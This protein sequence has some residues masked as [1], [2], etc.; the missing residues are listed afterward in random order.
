MIDQLPIELKVLILKRCNFL[1]LLRLRQ[2]SSFYKSLAENELAHRSRL[3]ISADYLDL[4]RVEEEEGSIP[5]GDFISVNRVIDFLRG[6]MENLM[7]LSLRYSPAR[8][9]L[10][11]LIQ[12][13]AAVPYLVSLDIS[14]VCGKPQID[15]DAV[16]ALPYFRNLK[17]LKMDGF[18]ARKSAG[19][20]CAHRI[21]VP[22]I[23]HMHQLEVLEMESHHDTISRILFSMRESQTI[24]FKLKSVRF[25]VRHCSAFYP[26]LLIWFL[27][28]HRSLCSV[29][30]RNA[31]F[32]TSDQLRRFYSA[33]IMLPYLAEVR[34]DGCTS[35]DR[36]DPNMQI[37]YT[38]AIT[39][40]GAY[41][42]GTVRS[43]RFDP[44]TNH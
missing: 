20:G 22:P 39:A 40:K 7:E 23:R 3:D 38:K 12:L 19:R 5:D 30:I 10:S 8:L 1:T 17:V 11:N 25:G 34:L 33:L 21:D 18:V 41:H 15:G 24:L 4:F 44:D 29:R 28:T 42:E 37:Q 9:T 43:M 36:V 2:V 6:Y 13:A 35:C 16:H 32:A 14:Q 31:L 27:R 26:E